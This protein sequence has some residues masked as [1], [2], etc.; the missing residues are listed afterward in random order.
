VDSQGVQT[1]RGPEGGVP[2]L[3]MGK[4]ALAVVYEQRRVGSGRRPLF[5]ERPDA[6]W[7]NGYRFVDS[8]RF[9]ERIP[10]SRR[11]SAPVA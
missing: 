4:G 7:V 6:R 3:G 9:Q 8:Y 11:K 5:D 1:G 10:P 2:V